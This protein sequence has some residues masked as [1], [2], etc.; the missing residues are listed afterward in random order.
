MVALTVPAPFTVRISEYLG[1]QNKLS[2]KNLKAC[3]FVPGGARF[4]KGASP[5]SALVAGR[6]Q[7]RPRK[8]V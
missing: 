5:K 3:F 1:L 7:P 4:L 8:S 2:S 6:I